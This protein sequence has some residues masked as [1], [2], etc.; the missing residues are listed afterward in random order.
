[1]AQEML[2]RHLTSVPTE[3]DYESF[4]DTLSASTRGRWFLA[5]Y[6][7]RNR[8][9]DT[10]VLL[11]ALDRIEALVR[12]QGPQLDRVHG[13]LRVLLDTL[14][15]ARPDV[16]ATDNEKLRAMKL[17]A[18]LNLL[19]RRI[20]SIVEARAVET[21]NDPAPQELGAHALAEPPAEPA[22]RVALAVVPP[23]EEPQL[24]LPSPA[25]GPPAIAFVGPPPTEAASLIDL[26]LETGD[27]HPTADEPDPARAF[28]PLA[29]EAETAPDRAALPAVGLV[30]EP[31]PDP[32]APLRAMTDEERLAIFT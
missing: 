4:C 7:R 27:W 6:T 1:M 19:E 16:D 30:I 18:L 2:A 11:A 32:L 17:I 23:L 14:R 25:A 28:V 5:E 21:P 3:A 22:T 10:A 31:K 29:L 13:E 12:Q 20:E 26:E 15:L 24:P 9:A 8:N